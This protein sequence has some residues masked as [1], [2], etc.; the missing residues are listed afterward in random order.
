[1]FALYTVYLNKQRP[2]TTIITI[3]HNYCRCCSRPDM[4][5]KIA[6]N[7]NNKYL[8]E[9]RANIVANNCGIF[10]R[11]A[12]KLILEKSNHNPESSQHSGIAN[13]R[14]TLI[15]VWEVKRHSTRYDWP[16]SP[17][18]FDHLS[19]QQIA[20]KLSR[21]WNFIQQISCFS[22]KALYKINKIYLSSKTN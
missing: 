17:M 18:A 16:S 5:R 21:I 12:N 9:I 3:N 14:I 15:D 10:Q 4:T 1:M 8:T 2:K 22:M 7:N 6:M 20:I 13:N 11:I 19:D